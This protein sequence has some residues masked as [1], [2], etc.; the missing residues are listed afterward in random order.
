MPQ[1]SRTSSC[2][3]SAS[4]QAPISVSSGGKKLGKVAFKFGEPAMHGAKPCSAEFELTWFALPGA[5]AYLVEVAAVEGD[6]P[7]MGRFVL[8]RSHAVVKRSTTVAKAATTK[9]I[10]RPKCTPNCYRCISGIACCSGRCWG[11]PDEP[12]CVGQNQPT[13]AGGGKDFSKVASCL[14]P[15][16]PCMFNSQCCKGTCLDIGG[17]KACAS[18]E[19]ACDEGGD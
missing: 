8:A 1:R 11:D 14:P 18:Y 2:D 4:T 15:C 17:S 10:D 7:A 16:H 5:K 13:C 12:Y 6:D 9:K 19:T 3:C